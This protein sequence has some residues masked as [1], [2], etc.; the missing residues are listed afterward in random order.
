MYF[1]HGMEPSFEWV[2]HPPL[3]SITAVVGGSSFLAIILRVCS[4]LNP[5]PAAQ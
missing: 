1:R 3:T 5:L 4:P 2:R